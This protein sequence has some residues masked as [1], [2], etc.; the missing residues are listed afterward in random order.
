MLA[1][2]R[3]ESTLSRLADIHYMKHGSVLAKPVSDNSLPTHPCAEFKFILGRFLHILFPQVVATM[4][5]SQNR[6]R[7]GWWA[8][9]QTQLPEA[10]AGRA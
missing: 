5:S 9:L 6:V 2:R 10:E 1:E 8:H 7:Y 4:N 3:Q